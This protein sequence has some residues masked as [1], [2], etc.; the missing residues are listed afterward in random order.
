MEKQVMK[1]SLSGILKVGDTVLW[2]GS[3]GQDLE[4][5]AV[6]LKIEVGDH[7]TSIDEIP[8]SQTNDRSIVV[9]L[10]NGSW[11]YGNQIFELI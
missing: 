3:W 10:D 9:I 2:K 7:C 6:V 11:A 8:W 4:K 5:N 1:N